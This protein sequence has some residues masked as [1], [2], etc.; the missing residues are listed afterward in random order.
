MRFNVELN[1]FIGELVQ[2]YL[3]FSKKFLLFKIYEE[4]W[5]EVKRQMKEVNSLW[6][7][8]QI[9]LFTMTSFSDALFHIVNRFPAIAYYHHAY[10]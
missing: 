6:I 1:R 8:I 5:T 9:L 7:F 2:I 10:I 4:K 3:L